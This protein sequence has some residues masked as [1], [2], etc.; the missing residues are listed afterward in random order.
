MS[1]AEEPF[2]WTFDDSE[3]RGPVIGMHAEI[4]SEQAEIPTHHHA[5]GQLV[6]ALEGAVTCEVP[7]AVWMVPPRCGVWVPWDMPHSI[8]VTANARVCY[9]FI[10][11]GRTSLPL[12][13]C[14]L[15]LSPLVQALILDLAD[16]DSRYAMNSPTGRKAAVLLEELIKMP[17]EQLYLPTSND[18][19]I[20]QLTQLLSED[21]ADRSTLTQWAKRLATSERTLGRLMERETGLSF[22][23]W[24][25]QLHLLVALRQLAGGENVQQV[26]A[27]L[28]YDS[29][30]A[31]ITM[32][33]K[34]T[35][36]TPGRYFSGVQASSTLGSRVSVVAIEDAQP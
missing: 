2:D 5:Q 4:S 34:L 10:Q 14:T 31:F 30:N 6:M 18:P 3:A 36:Q 16:Q 33:K 7:N 20:R 27:R 13:C 32:F 15:A 17:V 11:P 26:A 12:E 23:R 19:R 25:Q 9:L 29:V 21:P 28:G 1:A 22:R 8:N 35:G 24:R